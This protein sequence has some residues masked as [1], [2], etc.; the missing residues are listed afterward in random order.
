MTQ[1]STESRSGTVQSVERVFELLEA[2]ADAGGEISFSDLSSASDLPMP[3][4]HRLLRTCVTLGYARQLPSRRYALGARLIPLGERGRPGAR[5]VAQ[6]RLA[7]LVAELGETARSWRCWTA[8]RWSMWPSSRHRMRCGCSQRLAAGRTCTTPASGRRSWPPC[9][10]TRY[11]IESDCGWLRPP[12]RAAPHRT[13]LLDDLAE[14]RARGFAIDDEEQERG[15]RR[16]AVG[17]VRRHRWRCRS[18]V[19]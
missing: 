11:V 10:T 12:R 4:I 3:T 14:I 16:Y 8:T 7:Q 13:L 17:L 6:P 9:P 15:V 2:I 19:R 1:A 5:R 18:P